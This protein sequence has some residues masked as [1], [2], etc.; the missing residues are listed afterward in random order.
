V[1]IAS[2]WADD[3]YC[4]ELRDLWSPHGVLLAQCRQLLALL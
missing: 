4:E 1:S 2:R 3:G